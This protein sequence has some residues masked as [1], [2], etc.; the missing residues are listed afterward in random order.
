MKKRSVQDNDLSVTQQQF[1]GV[2]MLFTGE[3]RG[4]KGLIEAKKKCLRE[5]S[6]IPSSRI[7]EIFDQKLAP[8]DPTN[9]YR[10]HLFDTYSENFLEW[11]WLLQLDHNLLFCG[12]GCKKRLVNKFVDTC[13]NGEDVLAI[14]GRNTSNS[15]V[16]GVGGGG[17]GGGG[18]V[19]NNP[20]KII[21]S[22]LDTINTTILPSFLR[23]ELPS[24]SSSATAAFSFSHLEIYTRLV[25]GKC[26]YFQ[27]FL[28]IYTLVL[29]FSHIHCH[30]ASL[31]FQ[32][33]HFIIY[34]CSLT[35]SLSL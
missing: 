25:I 4:N 33:H 13:L 8:K 35:I 28:K 19:N 34:F 27:L 26:F 5:G 7:M 2:N 16:S 1:H 23:V 6:V 21:R 30:F 12:F 10:K 20:L 17:G 9:L 31:H 15:G 11:L 24:A 14:S 32:F 18:S 29:F 22:L 3:R